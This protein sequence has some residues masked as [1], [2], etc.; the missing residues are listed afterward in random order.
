MK[1][2][3]NYNRAKRYEEEKGRKFKIRYDT[4]D[5]NIPRIDLAQPFSISYPST[6]VQG[7]GEEQRIG[8]QITVTRVKIK[9]HI[10]WDDFDRFPT[11]V[12]IMLLLD[13]QANVD[14]P[15]DVLPFF[16]DR[17]VYT[18]IDYNQEQRFTILYDRMIP[19]GVTVPQLQI[20]EWPTYLADGDF[21]YVSESVFEKELRIHLEATSTHN[22]SYNQ[23]TPLVNGSGLISGTGGGTDTLSIVPGAGIIE[24]S[25][26]PNDF[27]MHTAGNMTVDDENPFML[28][29]LVVNPVYDIR[30]ITP[31]KPFD[32][33]ILMNITIKYQ[34]PHPTPTSNDI[35]VIVFGDGAT[36]VM[37]YESTIYYYD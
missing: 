26:V 36:N 18:M 16:N 24:P 9:G 5:F 31:S 27:Q 22:L 28:H 33:D 2:A 25:P 15:L 8:G 4:K 11:H 21:S 12:R 19:R 13:K 1:E 30:Y 29:P 32:I 7:T 10:E 20:T 23:T 6:I 14:Q 17:T 3:N 35:Y 34:D 37:K